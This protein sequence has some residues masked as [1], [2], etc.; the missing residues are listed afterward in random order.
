MAV[1][2]G[3]RGVL[4]NEGFYTSLKRVASRPLL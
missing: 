3:G 4:V 2:M 1:R